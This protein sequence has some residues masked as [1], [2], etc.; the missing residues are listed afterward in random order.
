MNAI[1]YLDAAALRDLGYAAAAEALDSA[2]RGGLEPAEDLRRVPTPFGDGE[3]L[4]MP[5]QAG[6][7]L[8]VKLVTVAP[9]NPAR[10]LPRIQGVYVLF[11]RATAAPVAIADGAAVTNLRTPAVSMVVARR[12]LPDRPVHVVVIGAGPQGRAHCEAL[13]AIAPGRVASLTLVARSAPDAAD[14]WFDETDVRAASPGEL[15][16]LLA[17]ADLVVCATTSEEPLFDAGLVRDGSLV[18]AIGSHTPD[19]RELQAALL[20]RSQV[21]VEDPAT[22]LREAGDVVLAVGE[23]ALAPEE[24]VALTDVVRGRVPLAGDRPVVFKTTGMS[25]EDLVVVSAAWDKRI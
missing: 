24:L 22:A 14:P 20:G 3:L 10:G 4:L 15:P 7:A 19:A 16:G 18:V 2:L 6:H 8:G 13:R 21:V 11:D 25:W 12:W 9:R 23:G 1:P 17:A 5:S